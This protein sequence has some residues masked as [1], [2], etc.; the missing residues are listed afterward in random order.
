MVLIG[1]RDPKNNQNQP[2][3]FYFGVENI[4][5]NNF[6]FALLFNKNTLGNS[7][8]V[9]R[10]RYFSIDD[11]ANIRFSSDAGGSSTSFTLDSAGVA[12]VPYS[13]VFDLTAPNSVAVQITSSSTLFDSAYMPTISPIDGTATDGNVLEG[14]ILIFIATDTYPLSGT[15]S[16]TIYCILTQT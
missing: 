3:A 6:P 5:E 10:L 12:S 2:S 9:G 8:L 4:V 11:S 7:L 1:E 13:V 16:S 15:Y 14:D